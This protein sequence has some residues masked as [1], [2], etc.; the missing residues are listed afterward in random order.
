MLCHVLCMCCVCVVY[1]LHKLHIVCHCA[2]MLGTSWH[3][4]RQLFM[5]LFDSSHSGTCTAAEVANFVPQM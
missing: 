2:A 3:T 1:V 4:L 5:T